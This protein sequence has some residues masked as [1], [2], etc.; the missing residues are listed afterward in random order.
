MNCLEQEAMFEKL[1]FLLLVTVVSFL[2]GWYAAWHPSQFFSWSGGVGTYWQQ[3]INK[4]Q[5][6]P[7]EYVLTQTAQSFTCTHV[8]TTPNP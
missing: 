8:V 6:C 3:K 4:E 5:T 1:I 2:A 7:N